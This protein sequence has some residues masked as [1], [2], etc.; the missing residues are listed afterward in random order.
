MRDSYL[1]KEKQIQD[2]KAAEKQ[3]QISSGSDSISNGNTASSNSNQQSSSTSSSSS[4]NSTNHTSN[5]KAS[6]SLSNIS[7]PQLNHLKDTAS[8]S[9]TNYSYSL[10]RFIVSILKKN[11]KLWST[12]LF[13]SAALA[14]LI[15]ISTRNHSANSFKQRKNFRQRKLSNYSV[16]SSN[17]NSAS[18]FWTGF[19]NL[20]SS[21]FFQL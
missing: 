15:H 9:I 16:V 14:V 20:I 19:S 17:S 13:V 5:E 11:M 10:W 6:H 7:S 2:K 4:N 3:S 8:E 1:E 18:D 12:M 21:F